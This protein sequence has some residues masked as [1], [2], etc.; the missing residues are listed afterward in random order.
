MKIWAIA[1]ISFMEC[2]RYRVIYFIF[3]MAVLFI[4]VGKGCNPGTVKGNDLFFDQQTRQKMAMGVAFHGIVFWTMM[5]C[6]L[7]SAGALSRELEDGTA[8]M[9]LSRPVHR[10]SFI[11]GKL[12]SILMLSTL[13]LFLLG[14]IFFVLFYIEVGMINLRIF[15]SFALMILNLLMYAL[16]GLLFSLFIPRLVIPLVCFVIYITSIWSSL[17]RYFEKI[18]IVWEPSETV[19]VIHASLPR[20]GDLQFIGSAFISENPELS[21]LIVPLCS[22][23]LY[24]A[25]LW[26]LIVFVFNKKQIV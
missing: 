4:L 8:V 1:K 26:S 18:K 7:V 10:S 19:E 17:P 20:L 13:N 22:T 21:I 3:I 12:L 6:G 24:C 14:G 11:A 25:V 15:G 5:L 23:V 16:M 2:I 9:S